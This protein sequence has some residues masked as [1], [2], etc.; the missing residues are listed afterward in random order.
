MLFLPAVFFIPGFGLLGMAGPFV[1]VLVSALEGALVVG[2]V[3]ALG[4]AL[5]D[6]GVSADL[7]IKYE[8]AIKSDQFLMIIHGDQL[9]IDTATSILNHT[10]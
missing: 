1:S 9:D 7:I 6:L 5:S 8:L 3:S 2:G 10:S 4:A